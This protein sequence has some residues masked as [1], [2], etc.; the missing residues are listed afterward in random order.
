MLLLAAL[1]ARAPLACAISTGQAPLEAGT[2]AYRQSGEGPVILLLH[3]LFAEKEQWDALICRLA[4]AGYRAIAPDLPGYG[5]SRGFPITDYALESQVERLH[6]LQSQLGLGRIDLAGNS[7][8]GAIAALYTHRH[9]EQVRTLA[10]LG[11][12]LGVTDWG[13]EV[14]AAIRQGVNPF[15]PLDI[16]Q[17][18]LELSLLFAVPPILSDEIKAALVREYVE[19]LQHYQQVWAIIGLEMRSLRQPD[20]RVRAPTLI[21]WGELDRVF[22]LAEAGPLWRPFPRAQRVTLKDAGHLLHLERP[23]DTALIYLDF[24][25]GA[26]RPAGPL[27]PKS[28]D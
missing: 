7:M 24:L 11:A 8:G 17:L 28:R 20:M 18:D 27:Q 1:P 2:I 13:P 21:L 26:A 14:R 10:L 3:G 23:A 6:E 25:R 4:D 5:Q 22:A 12:P 19:H 15:I 9:P 16:E